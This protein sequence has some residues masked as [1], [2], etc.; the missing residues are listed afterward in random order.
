MALDPNLIKLRVVKGAEFRR[1]SPE[2]PDQPKLD[3]KEVD[4]HPEP[5]LFRKREPM[6]DLALHLG[7][8]VAHR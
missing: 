1:K 3:G 8:R 6:L 2:G 4:S 7:K 5:C